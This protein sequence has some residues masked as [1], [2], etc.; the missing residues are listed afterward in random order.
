[1]QAPVYDQHRP[2]LRCQVRL[3]EFEFCLFENPPPVEGYFPFSGANNA[4][5]TPDDVILF[6]GG[7]DS[8]A[9]TVEELVA[10][11][12]KVALVSHRSATKIV[13][14]QK[15]LVDQLRGRFGANRYFTF[16][17]GHILKAASVRSRPT[18]RDRF[19]SRH[20]AP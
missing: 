17:F 16:P 5:F 10:H 12:K 20:W 6:S 8:F 4:G 7:L 18:G 15:Y 19:C 1:M 3:G 2:E 13:G 9:G 11:G 14:A